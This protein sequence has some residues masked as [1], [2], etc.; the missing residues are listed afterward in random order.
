MERRL[1][2]KLYKKIF[3]HRTTLHQQH[4]NLFLTGNNAEKGRQILNKR[5]Q[6][7]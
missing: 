1:N 3:L 7:I 4:S 2:R 5:V 6:N